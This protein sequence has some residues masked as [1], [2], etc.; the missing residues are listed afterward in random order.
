MFGEKFLNSLKMANSKKVQEAEVIHE[1]GSLQNPYSLAE[2]EIL[3]KE[4]LKNDKITHFNGY[5]NKSNDPKNPDVKHF[6]F[7]EKDN[8]NFKMWTKEFSNSL[9][10]YQKLIDSGVN[11]S[12]ALAIIPRGIK[13]MNVKNYDLYNLTT[14]Y[15]SLR[16]CGTA[17]AEMREITEKESKLV[18][19]NF[20][21][22]N[23]ISPKCHYTGFCPELS[24]QGKKCMKINQRLK[25]YNEEMHKN[26]QDLRI[27][28]IEEKL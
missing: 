26:F 1:K 21:Y 2:L 6:N 10:V 20:P 16:L 17:E 8:K 28:N 11:E 13:M 9:N 18:K 24:Y 3:K 5:V 12:E 7:V 22:P 27:K 23:L 19:D 25:N 15:M 14:G 4:R